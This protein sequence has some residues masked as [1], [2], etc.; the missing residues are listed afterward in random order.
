MITRLSAEFV[1]E[2]VQNLSAANSADRQL[3]ASATQTRR[4]GRLGPETEILVL[5][6]TVPN[7]SD[8]PFMPSMCTAYAFSPSST[9]LY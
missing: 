2:A 3:S 9:A 5:M 6:R 1:A 4:A 7:F 8:Y